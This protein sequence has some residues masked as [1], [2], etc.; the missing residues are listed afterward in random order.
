MASSTER[1]ALKVQGIPASPSQSLQIG[2]GSTCVGLHATHYRLSLA[3]SSTLVNIFPWRQ[4]DQSLEPDPRLGS[5]L[6][7]LCFKW[8]FGKTFQA[9]F[10]L[11]ILKVNLLHQ[12]VLSSGLGVLAYL[13]HHQ[14]PTLTCL[15]F[16]Q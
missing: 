10:S 7:E 5:T 16:N 6:P 11:F 12:F 2:E 1:L 15:G 4:P 9:C 3:A 14:Q 13:C 8:G